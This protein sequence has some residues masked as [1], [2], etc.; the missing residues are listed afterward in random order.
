MIERETLYRLV[1]ELRDDIVRHDAGLG[2]GRI[3]D[4][5]DDLHQAVFHRDLDAQ[6]TEF[7]ARLHLHVAEALRIHVAR[8]RIEPG[9]HAV[10][11][12]FDQLRV[13]GLLDVIGAHALE[14]VAEKVEV[15][16][17]V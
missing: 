11:R 4:W 15:P 12:R 3:V 7:A 10:D 1:V 16:V 14:H 5:R 8:M 13:I 2:R 6:P 17:S 9:Q